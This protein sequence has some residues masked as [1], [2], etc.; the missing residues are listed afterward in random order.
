M[1][2]GEDGSTLRDNPDAFVIIIFVIL[3]GLLL[4]WAQRKWMPK[5]SR[6]NRMFFLGVGALILGGVF[7]GYVYNVN[8]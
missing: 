8:A 2:L 5:M 6:R 7:Y 3:A 4:N 1:Y